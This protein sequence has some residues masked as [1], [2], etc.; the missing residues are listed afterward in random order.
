MQ[1]KNVNGNKALFGFSTRAVRKC[2]RTVS[3]IIAGCGRF[4]GFCRVFHAT[5]FF[6]CARIISDLLLQPNL[7][8]N[9]LFSLKTLDFGMDFFLVF[10][11]WWFFA[12]NVNS[13]PPNDVSYSPIDITDTDDFIDDAVIISAATVSPDNGVIIPDFNSSFQT[14]N[15]DFWSNLS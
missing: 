5:D 7:S 11:F 14:M 12:T 6:S 2:G 8:R 13:S 3:A 1:P 4:D 9:P 10:V 15:V